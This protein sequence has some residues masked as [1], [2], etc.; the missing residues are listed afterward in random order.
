M[1]KMCS[2]EQRKL[3]MVHLNS[4]LDLLN[5][6]EILHFSQH[7]GIYVIHLCNSRILS[8]LWYLYL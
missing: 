8:L 7:C 6:V 1:K 4:L 3:I 5:V 2:N